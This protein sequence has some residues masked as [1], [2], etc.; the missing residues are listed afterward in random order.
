MIRDTRQILAYRS[1]SSTVV[2][3]RLMKGTP[4][5]QVRRGA[6]IFLTS[7]ILEIE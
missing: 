7:H 1:I 6:T 2:W 5:D 3:A 4:L